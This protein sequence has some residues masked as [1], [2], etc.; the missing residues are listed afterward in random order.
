MYT[1]QL[2]IQVHVLIYTVYKESVNM[3]AFLTP[4]HRNMKVSGEED[5]MAYFGVS[6]M[7]QH[8]VSSRRVGVVS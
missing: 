5:R 7:M 3:I 6:V 2:Y 1:K 8:P 4:A